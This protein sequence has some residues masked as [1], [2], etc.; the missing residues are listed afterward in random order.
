MEKPSGFSWEELV[1]DTMMY[2]ALTSGSGIWDNTA[3]KHWDSS[4]APQPRRRSWGGHTGWSPTILCPSS[5]LQPPCPL[6]PSSSVSSSLPLSLCLSASLPVLPLFTGQDDNGPGWIMV[7]MV[8][9]DSS[10][11]QLSAALLYCYPSTTTLTHWRS[12]LQPAENC[13]T[14]NL[15]PNLHLGYIN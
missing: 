3:D 13:S 6:L 2:Q 11:P 4:T 14:T 7:T 15:Q 9:M 5:S 8:L 1:E 10:H 12:P